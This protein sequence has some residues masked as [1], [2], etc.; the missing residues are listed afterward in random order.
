MDKK[1]KILIVEDERIIAL[2]MRRKLKTMGYDVS[3][4]VSSGE[5][6]VRKAEELHP[7]LV[8]M[9]IILQGEMDG[10]EAA[11]QI[12]TRFDI[13][14]VYATA[15][16]SDARLEDIT[17]TEPF[18][19]LFKP[20]EDVEL[21]AAIEMA[22]YK[23]KMDK[24]LRERERRYNALYDRS[25]DGVYIHDFEGN[26][27]DAN[28]AAL[29]MLGFEREDIPLINFASLLSEDQMP[30]AMK[31]FE[32]LR[33]TGT[34]Q[35][36]TGFRLLQKDGGHIHVETKASVIYRDEKPYAIQGIARDITDRREAEKALHDSEKKYRTLAETTNDIAFVLDLDGKFTY[37]SP[38]VEKLTGYS[39]QDFLGRPFTEF[40][41][42]EYVNSEIKNFQ[43]GLAGKEFPLVEIEVKHKDGGTVPIELNV[44]SLPDATGKTTGRIGVARDIT[45]RRKANEAL[46][47][48]EE[49][50]RLIFGNTPLGILHFDE[51]GIITACNDQFVKIIGSTQ[52]VLVGLNMLNL[53]DKD[54]VSAVAVAINGKPGYYEDDYHSV[55]A[56]KVTPVRIL[57]APIISEKGEV[58]GGVGIIDDITER[59]RAEKALR[60]SEERFRTIFESR[61]DGYAELDLAGRFTFFNETVL[62][63]MGFPP[64]ELMGI[65]YREYTSPETA[66]R[67]YGIFNEIY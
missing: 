4:I 55:T 24:K 32:E 14:V 63:I 29:K 2:E 20:F 11:G 13:P 50:Y 1:A 47:E 44:T 8:L 28:T 57:F 56:N 35:N 64:E 23:Y 66:K 9:D 17:R 42:P 26:F 21:H 39:W 40:I 61:E 18:G 36:I 53:P 62:R 22:L 45:D 37:V 65:S 48:S 5:D 6:A 49:K 46:R 19:C 16:V 59:K 10:V 25:F 52:E 38:V 67:L 51:K 60:K 27:I 58:I 43:E 33:E 31:A 12:R 30:L 7:D 41:A 3:A 34:Q 15:N 54:I